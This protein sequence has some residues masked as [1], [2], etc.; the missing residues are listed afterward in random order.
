MSY[1]SFRK[2]FIECKNDGTLKEEK[3]FN[4]GQIL[5]MCM[6]YGGQCMSS[7]CRDERSKK[8]NGEE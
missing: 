6:K 3:C 1:K 4:C 7:K 8:T 5:L 2:Q